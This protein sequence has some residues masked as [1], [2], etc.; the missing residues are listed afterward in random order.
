VENCLLF[1]LTLVKKG[2]RLTQIFNS[3]EEQRNYEMIR[4]KKNL[5]GE[6]I[7]SYLRKVGKCAILPLPPGQDNTPPDVFLAALR[8]GVLQPLSPDEFVDPAIFNAENFPLLFVFGNESYI[9]TVREYGDGDKAII[10]Y[11]KEG[12]TIISLVNGPTPFAYN[13]KG[14]LLPSYDRFGFTLCGS[15]GT[16]PPAN[17]QL[18]TMWETPPAGEKFIFRRNPKQKILVNVPDEFPFYDSG[19]LRWRPMGNF[20]SLEEAE[21]IPL[22]SLYDERGKERGDGAALVRFK[23]GELAPGRVV[24]VWFRLWQDKRFGDA[25]LEDIVKAIASGIN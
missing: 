15:G 23:K 19:D 1:A 8:T 10:N 13:E 3:L 17:P 11:L 6:R 12:G 20:W 5:Q 16:H 2:D 4:E 18:Y 14:E 22:L 7:V 9:Q 21:Y 25:L 24:Y